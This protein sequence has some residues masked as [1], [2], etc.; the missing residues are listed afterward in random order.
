MGLHSSMLTRRQVEII[1]LL[2]N[3]CYTE[4]AL[5][6]NLG[7]QQGSPMSPVLINPVILLRLPYLQIN[8][9]Y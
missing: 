1:L 5:K 2:Q 3:L 6:S 7:V 8:Y 4:I 9:I